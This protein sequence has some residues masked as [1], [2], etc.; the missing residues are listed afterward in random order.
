MIGDAYILAGG[1]SSRM[2]E[3]KGLKL[4]NGFPIIQYEINVLTTCFSEVKINTQNLEYKKFNLEIVPDIVSNAGPIGG[5]YTSL[6]NSG[7]D[8]F[9]I[10]CDMPFITKEAVTYLIKNHTEASTTVAGYNKKIQPLFGIYTQQILPLLEE[11]IN[12][13]QFKMRELIQD[14]QGEIIEMNPVVSSK[15]FVNINNPEDFTQIETKRYN[16]EN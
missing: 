16:E 11:K 13:K 12:K 2:G 1:K 3:D 5:I 4:L 15:V 6:K 14:T 7:K 8:I 10:A 9:V